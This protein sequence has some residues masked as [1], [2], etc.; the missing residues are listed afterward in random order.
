MDKSLI[1]CTCISCLKNNS[2][3]KLVAQSV[4]YRYQKKTQILLEKELSDNED[5]NKIDYQ[6]SKENEENESEIN[7]IKYLSASKKISED[8][9]FLDNEDYNIFNENNSEEDNDNDNDDDDDN[10]IMQIDEER[11]N[12][13]V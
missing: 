4:Y 9:D 10:N 2:D 5:M 13:E 11:L 6:M 3:G 1:L 8:D 12:K 7:E